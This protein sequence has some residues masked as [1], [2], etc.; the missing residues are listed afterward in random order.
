M[1]YT[2]PKTLELQKKLQKQYM[3]KQILINYPDKELE[4][5]VLAI[6]S[7][8]EL[9]NGFKLKRWTCQEVMRIYC[10]LA[11]E[12]NENTF[13]IGEIFM[14]DAIQEAI[15]K[16]QYFWIT[17]EL[18]GPLH[19]L[20]VIFSDEC[21]V[22]GIDSTLGC[23]CRS[24]NPSMT[25]APLVEQI[26]HLGGIP[27][28]KTNVPWHLVFSEASNP[29][30]STTINT[31]NENVSLGG[32]CG[33]LALLLSL[34]NCFVGFGTDQAG[35]LRIPANHAGIFTLKPTST[36]LRRLTSTLGHWDLLAPS[37]GPMSC[38]L[39]NLTFMYQ[40]LLSGSITPQPSHFNNH[41]YNEVV[42]GK[43]LRVGMYVDDNVVRA[44]PTAR[45][46]VATV[47]NRLV[48]KGH[49]VVNF[50]PPDTQE[51]IILYSKLFSSDRAN[52]ECFQV[53]Q[54]QLNVAVSLLPM[55][56]VNRIPQYIRSWICYGL[57][58]FMQDS[59]LTALSTFFGGGSTS[60][61]SRNL[62]ELHELELER[63]R[64]CKLFESAMSNP[65]I[66]I[67][68]C[69]VTA[70]PPLPSVSSPFVWPGSF[71]SSLFN[72]LDYPSGIIPNVTRVLETDRVPNAIRYIHDNMFVLRTARNFNLMAVTA[73]EETNLC[74]KNKSILGIPVGVQI[75]SK[76]NNEEMVLAAMKVIQTLLE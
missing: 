13:C 11:L 70:C 54:T 66:D 17:G 1:S 5:I 12:L 62:S 61:S 29:V 4:S 60:K 58:M 43:K 36:R 10:K 64:Y 75:V 76:P 15:E 25:D 68:I 37:S 23:A 71:Y 26:K 31:K 18:L 55:Y 48:E 46:A 65:E 47:A 19:G 73:I 69:P 16:D 38:S 74:I 3:L 63:E 44:S 28:C 7:I 21:D 49:T 6:T 20:P 9:I 34:S 2:K 51:A 56:L 35:G 40:T 53:Q 50:H 24:M 52:P 32:R 67:L 22:S 14:E 30:F 41:I 8:H 72:L 33:A 59:V 42:N 57:G 39:E 45:R 27:F